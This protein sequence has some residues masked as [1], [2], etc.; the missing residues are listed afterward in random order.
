MKRNTKKITLSRETLRLLDAQDLVM[1]D[2][3]A[4]YPCYPPTYGPSCYGTCPQ[5]P[6]TRTNCA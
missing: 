1:A 6:P 2:G 4:T 5:Q 3:G